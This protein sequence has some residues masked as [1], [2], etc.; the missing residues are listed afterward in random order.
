MTK[1]K[2]SMNFSLR[3]PPDLIDDYLFCMLKSINRM[4]H[5]NFNFCY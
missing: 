3:L 4:G 5:E 2:V 1:K